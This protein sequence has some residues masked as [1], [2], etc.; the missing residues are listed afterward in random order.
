MKN[1]LKKN[2]LKS[3]DRADSHILIIEIIQAGFSIMCIAGM[4]MAK[5][6]P[7]LLEVGFGSVIGLGIGII[8]SKIS[9]SWLTMMALDFKR[10]PKISWTGV[11]FSSRVYT[12]ITLLGMLWIVLLSIGA[13]SVI[14]LVE[15]IY[16]HYP[17]IKWPFI[18]PKAPLIHPAAPAVLVYIIFSGAVC[19]LRFLHWYKRL[20][21]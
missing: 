12:H 10:E 4:I 3:L 1:N 20:P 9:I 16:Y 5:L 11:R 7:G 14:A 13:F 17:Q 15:L 6:W 19:C 18:T 2:D 8:C 21:N